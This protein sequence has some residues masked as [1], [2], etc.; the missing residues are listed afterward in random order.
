[1]KHVLSVAFDCPCRAQKAHDDF[2]RMGIPC[3]H[4]LGR[5]VAHAAV[6]HPLP[7]HRSLAEVQPAPRT[8]HPAVIL[9]L[10]TDAAQLSKV[11]KLIRRYGGRE[12]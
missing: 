3:R 5:R 6:P 2:C 7:Q 12:I 8:A 4:Q 9:N 11:R 10:S 1:M